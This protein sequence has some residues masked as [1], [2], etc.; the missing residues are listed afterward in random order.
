MVHFFVTACV[1]IKIIHQSRLNRM[2]REKARRLKKVCHDFRL[3]VC[4]EC[5]EGKVIKQK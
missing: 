3:S 2:H 5:D 4:D 1:C